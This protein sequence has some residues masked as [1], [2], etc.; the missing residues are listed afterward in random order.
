[1]HS[2]LVVIGDN[3]EASIVGQSTNVKIYPRDAQSHSVVIGQQYPVRLKNSG[4]TNG[5]CVLATAKNDINGA[6][7]GNW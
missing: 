2:T 1:M 4:G 5:I 3:I 7:V 6:N